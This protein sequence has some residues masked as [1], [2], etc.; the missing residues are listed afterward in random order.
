M[1]VSPAESSLPF[2]L[3]YL[4]Q[5]KQEGLAVSSVRVHL[6]TISA[7]HPWVSGWSI[8]SNQICS[9]LLKGLECLYP[10]V[11]PCLP[12]WDLNLVP[13]RL[14]GAPFKPLAT[15]SLLYLSWWLTPQLE[16]SQRSRPYLSAT[17]PS[18]L[19]GQGTALTPPFLSAEGSLNFIVTKTF[20]S[21][22]SIQSST[23]V[24]RN[25]GTTR[26]MFSVRSPSI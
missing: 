10:Q 8:F 12:P 6:T 23:L 14:T 1:A 18:L 7:F 11:R 22:S 4:L 9:Q 19:Q 24:R 13:T 21:Q 2:L 3:D 17:I 26:W 5:L 16:G 25:R 20:F 15:S